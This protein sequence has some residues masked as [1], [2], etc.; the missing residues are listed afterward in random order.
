MNPFLVEE[1]TEIMREHALKMPVPVAVPSDLV[2]PLTAKEIER[3]YK[4]ATPVQRGA[5]CALA[6]MVRESAG[7]VA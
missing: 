7:G 6:A 3:V 5:F 2:Q 1:L 4:I